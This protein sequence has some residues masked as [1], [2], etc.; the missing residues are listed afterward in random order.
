MAF[1]DPYLPSV[2]E[3]MANPSIESSNLEPDLDGLTTSYSNLTIHPENIEDR[4]PL[5]LVCFYTF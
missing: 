4:E 5:E 1:Q 3:L 2:E